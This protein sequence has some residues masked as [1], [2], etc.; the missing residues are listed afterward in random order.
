MHLDTE[1]VQTSD[2]LFA[3]QRRKR[4]AA[5]AADSVVGARACLHAPSCGERVYQLLTVRAAASHSPRAVV[6]DK[7]RAIDV[8]AYFAE[9][10]PKRFDVDG[11]GWIKNV[12]R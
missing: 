11:I 5:R 1:I 8:A 10:T 9:T 3:S 7:T 12:A 4:S 2:H 6:A